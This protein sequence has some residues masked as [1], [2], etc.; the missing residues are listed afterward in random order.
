M[1]QITKV[2]DRRQ[3]SLSEFYNFDF[4]NSQP[5]KENPLNK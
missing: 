3:R 5:F 4:E 2:L 1:D